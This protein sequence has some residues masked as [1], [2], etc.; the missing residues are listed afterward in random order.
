MTGWQA[1]QQAHGMGMSRKPHG[2]GLV[3]APMAWE[4]QLQMA[5]PMASRLQH[6]RLRGPWHGSFSTKAWHGS[7]HGGSFQKAHGKGASAPAARCEFSS[8]FADQT[9]IFSKRATGFAQGRSAAA[10]QLHPL[11]LLCKV[12]YLKIID[13]TSPKALHSAISTYFTL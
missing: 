2:K 9:K 10:N 11:H 3:V 1:G 6:Q 13:S 12:E 4:L 8:K 7:P 5:W